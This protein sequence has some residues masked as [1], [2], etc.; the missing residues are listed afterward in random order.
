MVRDSVFPSL[1]RRGGRAVKK[2]FPFRK[3]ADGVVAHRQ[4][5]GVRVR[6]VACERPPRLR[7]FGGFA[8]FS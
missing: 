4:C 1:Q 3:G 7:R 8:A 2:K 5:F 6:N